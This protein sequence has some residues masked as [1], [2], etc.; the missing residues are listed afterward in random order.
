MAKAATSLRCPQCA[1]PFFKKEGDFWRCET[2]GFKGM[3]YAAHPSRDGDLP[4]EAAS[5]EDAVCA[6]HPG[7]KAVAVCAGTGDYIC[8]LCRVT[9]KG[10][11]YSVQYLDGGGR[12]LAEQAFSKFLPRPDRVVKLLLLASVLTGPLSFALFIVSGF[13]RNRA[14]RLR[15]ENSVYRNAVSLTSM[16]ICWSLNL[17]YVLVMFLLILHGCMK[18]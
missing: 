12:V 16:W 15:R 17:L 2:C 5:P 11:D 14:V 9:L 13:F 7:K 10:R 1:S 18:P 3:V 4:A 6:N 8:S